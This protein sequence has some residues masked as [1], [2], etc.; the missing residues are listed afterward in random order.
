[1]VDCYR[2]ADFE[3]ES[4]DSR[5]WVAVQTTTLG[6]RRTNIRAVLSTMATITVEALSRPAPWPTHGESFTLTAV[7]EEDVREL[8]RAHEAPAVTVM[9]EANLSVCLDFYSHSPGGTQRLERADIGALIYR[10]KYAKPKSEA[11]AAQIIQAAVAYVKKHPALRRAKHVAAVPSSTVAGSALPNTLP[12]KLQAALSAALDMQDIHLTR[13]RARSTKQKD[14][15]AGPERTAHQ[16]N[17]LVVPQPGTGS[18]L[19]VD[20][21]LEYGDSM[22]EAVRAV[23]E[24]GFQKVFSLCLA[25]NRTGTTGYNFDAE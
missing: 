4:G 8:L 3:V 20:D 25:K 24:V 15:P 21:M 17:T 5:L 16:Q 10:A 7:S 14:L 23:R 18:V 9:T 13:V 2:V 19:I 1:M 6:A 22:N 12:A 11:A